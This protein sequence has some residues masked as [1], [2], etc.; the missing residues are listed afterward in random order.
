M[1]RLSRVSTQWRIVSQSEA[2]PMMTA[3]SEDFW[4]GMIVLS[5]EG[6]ISQAGSPFGFAQGGLCATFS[7]AETRPRD[8]AHRIHGKREIF[9]W[10]DFGAKNRVEAL[11]YR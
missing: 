6:R 8:C 7:H 5:L 10:P 11:R 9:R 2:L 3:T 1:P 4:S